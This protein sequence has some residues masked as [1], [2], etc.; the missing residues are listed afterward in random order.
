MSEQPVAKM[1]TMG[2]LDDD[3]DDDLDTTAN[4]LSAAAA[5]TG[6]RPLE[7]PAADGHAQI[8]RQRSEPGHAPPPAAADVAPAPGGLPRAN[9]D[10]SAM[11]MAA[12]E[13]SDEL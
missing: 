13:E 3:D 8:P 7:R 1:H 5:A 2:H 6:Y 11:T 4:P 12:M 9:S 10:R